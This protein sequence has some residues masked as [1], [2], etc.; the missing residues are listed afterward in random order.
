[1]T[2]IFVLSGIAMILQRAPRRLEELPNRFGDAVVYFEATEAWLRGADPW[3]VNSTFGFPFSGPPTALL[4]SLPLLPLGVGFAHAFWPVAGL[5][6]W[7]VTMYKLR[8]PPWWI[9][10]P[11]FLEGWFAGSPD[12]ALMGVALLGGG[13]IAAI[14]K[15][16]AI[17]ALIA[18]RRIPAVIIAAIGFLLTIPFLPWAQFLGKFDRITSS[19][20]AYAA[21]VSAWGNPPLMAAAAIA[22]LGLGSGRALL[23]AVPSLWP[24]S[25]LHYS[26][27]SARAGV[28]SAFLAVVL[29]I[30]GAAPVG[31][32]AYFIYLRV[33]PVAVERFTRTGLGPRLRR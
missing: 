10:F 33:L 16:Y 9:I 8:L 29:A 1:L 3:L 25:Q 12:P 19:L 5:L 26:V 28:E 23:L 22:L 21:H 17:P 14:A 32:V 30:P 2:A 11:P 4:L 13:A 31:V 7:L 27:F 24:N 15:P 20:D 18:E 6:G